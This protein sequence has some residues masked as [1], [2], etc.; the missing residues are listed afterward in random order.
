[1]DKTEQDELKGFVTIVYAT[2]YAG[3][4]NDVAASRLLHL[5]PS[6]LGFWNRRYARHTLCLQE[7]QRAY[8]QFSLNRGQGDEAYRKFH[9]YRVSQVASINAE[10]EAA[11]RLS[12]LIE[13]FFQYRG[14]LL[15]RRGFTLA[16][17]A[18][19]GSEDEEH[20]TRSL[21]KG[22]EAHLTHWAPWWS[23][24]EDFLRFIHQGL[25]LEL[26]FFQCF[27]NHS[28]TPTPCAGIEVIGG[29]H[30]RLNRL[31]E[32]DTAGAKLSSRKHAGDG[33]VLTRIQTGTSIGVLLGNRNLIAEKAL[34]RRR[35]ALQKLQALVRVYYEDIRG[36]TSSERATR[37]RKRI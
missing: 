25:S 7:I 27:L 33:L 23:V 26:N 16:V 9:E 29:L 8:A 19:H 31:I 18:S 14:E 6:I 11:E 21:I 3:L 36:L 1:M 30:N 17:R 10:C 15:S 34:V 13:N 12:R 37:K 4:Y 24:L 2:L 28:G 5:Y 32:E 35:Q 20:H 22:I